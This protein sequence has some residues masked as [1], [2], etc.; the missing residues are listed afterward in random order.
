MC[1]H[2]TSGKELFQPPTTDPVLIAYS[3]RGE[4][5]GVLVVDG[6]GDV[7][8]PAEELLGQAH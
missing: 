5:D 8:R 7:H 2:L 1:A 6:G 4:G 3:D